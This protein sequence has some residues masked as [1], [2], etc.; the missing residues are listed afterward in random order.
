MK[1][2]MPTA[3]TGDVPLRIALDAERSLEIGC[4]LSFRAD[5]PYAV[6]ATFRTGRADIQWTISRDLI[7]EGLVRPA[8]DGDVL[9]WPEYGAERLVVIALRSPGQDEAVMEGDWAAVADFLDKTYRIVEFGTESE[10]LDLDSWI[11]RILDQGLA[12]R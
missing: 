6:R 2:S 3:I 8:G 4:Q 11:D 1:S 7:A 12:G 10:Y 5:E 9:I